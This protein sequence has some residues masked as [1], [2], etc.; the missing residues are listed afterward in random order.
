MSPQFV[1]RLLK[2]FKCRQCKARRQGLRKFCAYHLRLARERWHTHVQHQLERGKCINCNR[3]HLPDQQRCAHCRET[4]RV[5]CR[6]WSRIHYRENYAA[7]QQKT[8]ET[9][10]CQKCSEHRPVD[11][12]H[13]Y[14]S[15]CRTIQRMWRLLCIEAGLMKRSYTPTQA[16]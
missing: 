12:D 11:G 9:G 15:I 16:V 3:K 4:N 1:R 7:L 10:L 6:A 2:K 13:L 14:C 5:K 8:R